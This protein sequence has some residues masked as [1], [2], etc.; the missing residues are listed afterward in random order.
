MG[1]SRLHEKSMVFNNVE[2][3]LEC[4]MYE[5]SLDP[6]F[7]LTNNEINMLPIHYFAGHITIVTSF[8][9]IENAVMILLRG[10]RPEYITAADQVVLGLDVEWKPTFGKN[11]RR[12]LVSLLQLAN[13][14][15]VVLFRLNM[16]YQE[17]QKYFP[18]QPFQ[19]PEILA[20]LFRNAH[21]AKVGVNSRS[22]A[23]KLIRDYG[24]EID[25]IFDAEK[26]PIILRCKPKGLR[27][28]AALFLGFRP[29][30]SSTMSNWEN[31]VLTE[32]QKLY[33]ATDAW[34]SREVYL[35][36]VITQYAVAPFI[37]NFGRISREQL[38]SQPIQ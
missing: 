35:N 24:I 36:L 19:L 18:S 11:A 30:S 3:L 10:K 31:K 23:A 33:A 1:L 32:S 28:L 29:L 20:N 22:D 21:I 17:Y 26:M 2:Y 34:C 16:L 12:S 25:G 27:G 8:N 9:E 5:N 6:L 37:T 15:E 14:T 13:A 38:L 7:S 4:I